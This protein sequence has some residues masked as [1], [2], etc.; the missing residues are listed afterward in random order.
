MKASSESL[1]QRF[2][3]LLER[4]VI[5]QSVI[6]LVLVVA[7]IYLWCQGREVPKALESLTFTVVAFWMGSKAQHT[8]DRN[9]GARVRRGP[10]EH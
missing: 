10:E 9:Q 6:T 8:V 1:G 4:S 3:D 5:I 2:F 7:C